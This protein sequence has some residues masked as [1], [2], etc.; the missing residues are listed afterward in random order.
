MAESE[1]GS[2]IIVEECKWTNSE[3]VAVLIK[4][5]KTKAKLLTFT[6]DKEIIP[7]LF[8]KNKQ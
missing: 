6:K 4:E 7:V 8:L 2:S 1:D 3:I 5:L